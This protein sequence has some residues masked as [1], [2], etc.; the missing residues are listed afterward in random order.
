MLRGRLIFRHLPAC[1]ALVVIGALCHPNSGLSQDKP[2]HTLKGQKDAVSSLAFS[3]DGKY[4]AAGSFD[5]SICLW[6]VEGGKLLRTLTGLNQRVS[7]VIF[8]PD[9]KSLAGGSWVLHESGA[10]TDA[11]GSSPQYTGEVKIWSVETGAVEKTLAWHTAPMWAIAYS[12]NGQQLAGGTGMVRKEDGRYYGQVIIW[13]ILRGE[14]D[15]TLTAHSAPV[16][17]VAFSRDGQK[18]AAGCGLDPEDNSYEVILWDIATGQKEQTLRGHTG[19]VISVAFSPTG[20]ILASAGADHTL[21]LWDVRSGALKQAL[22]QAGDLDAVPSRLAGGAAYTDKVKQE[23][24]GFFSVVQKGWTNAVSFSKDG[25]YL[26]SIGATSLRIWEVATGQLYQTITPS[27]RGI[28]SVAFSPDGKAIA[29]GNADG[30]VNLWDVHP[31]R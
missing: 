15:T 4:L 22:I 10:R 14:I 11:A 12:P 1:L 26:A 9:G 29:T 18:L 28:Y 2:W 7:S 25:K 8:S 6:D 17:S 23:S 27:T 20:E 5:N 31:S 21:R 30:V 16:W 19:R 24:P 3:P 13:D